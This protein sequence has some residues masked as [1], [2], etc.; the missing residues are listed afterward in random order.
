MSKAAKV[1]N[2]SKS[3]GCIIPAEEAERQGYIKDIAA[4]LENARHREVRI[5]WIFAGSLLDK[6][7][8]R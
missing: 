8:W 2:F 4:W 3:K 1:E 6:I 5:I 7:H